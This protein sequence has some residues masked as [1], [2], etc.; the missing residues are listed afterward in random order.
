MHDRIRDDTAPVICTLLKTAGII[1]KGSRVD[2]ELK[3]AVKG[4]AGLRPLDS[5]FWP[6]PSIKKLISPLFCMRLAD[7]TLP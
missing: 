3:Q 1:G 2:I 4:L 7:T 6:V 5:F